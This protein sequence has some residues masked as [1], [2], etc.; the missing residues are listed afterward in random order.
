M[1]VLTSHIVYGHMPKTGG[2][3]VSDVLKRTREGQQ[4]LR[5]HDGLRDLPVGVS[6]GRIYIGT[7]R[8]PWSWYCSWYC[9]AVCHPDYRERLTI[10]GAGKADFKSVLYGV[11]HPAAGREVVPIGIFWP[12]EWGAAGERRS[13]HD[14]LSSGTGL[15]SWVVHRVYG[16][17]SGRLIPGAF[18]ELQN[19]RQGLGSLLGRELSVEHFPPVN[20]T[21]RKPV[22]MDMSPVYDTEGVSWV[23]SADRQVAA[24]FGYR[25]PFSPSSQ[26]TL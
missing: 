25:D 20:L 9:H 6:E 7:I 2:S 26:R 8:D 14:W 21:S 18:L 1:P 10:Y 23:R 3:W 17:G 12:T 11:T 19:L 5:A 22:P 24:Y 15:Y 4:V 16:D 13:L